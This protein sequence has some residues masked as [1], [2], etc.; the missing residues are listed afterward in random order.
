MSEARIVGEKHFDAQFYY[1]Q[2]RSC[3]Y[4]ARCDV[5]GRCFLGALL[6][7]RSANNTADYTFQLEGNSV[8]VGLRG[9]QIF[10]SHVKMF[11][12]PEAQRIPDQADLFAGLP[13]NRPIS[14]SV[15]DEVGIRTIMNEAEERLSPGE[16]ALRLILDTT[17]ALIH[18]GR[19]T[20]IWI[21][22]TGRG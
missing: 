4:L 20:D 21:T 10:R 1:E 15:E 3:W 17:P 19:P 11:T 6:A 5:L 14:E 13:Y 8:G 22:S 16:D 7:S 9:K 2:A 12:A 18:T